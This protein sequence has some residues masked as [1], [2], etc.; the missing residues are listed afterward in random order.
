[1]ADPSPFTV[2]P[3]GVAVA[4]RLTPKS[5]ANKIDGIEA[6]ADGRPYVK[7]RVSA[8]PEKGKANA[9]LLKL[10][11]KCWGLRVG[12]L[13]V[14]AGGKSRRKTVMIHG[15]PPDLLR[16]LTEWRIDRRL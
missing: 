1:M 12:D 10:L 2:R 4:V 6:A 15:E 8:A 16:R 13:E 3:R 7:A 9:A 5:S 11:A 14:S